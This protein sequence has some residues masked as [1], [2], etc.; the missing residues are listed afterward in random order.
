MHQ[1]EKKKVEKIG[2]IKTNQ[3]NAMWEKEDNFDENRAC[4][5]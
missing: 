4:F 1:R 5:M 2:K 3:Q